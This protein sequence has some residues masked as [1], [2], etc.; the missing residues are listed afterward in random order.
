MYSQSSL[1]LGKFT[2]QGTVRYLSY[3]T[4]S[5]LL[6]T[7]LTYKLPKVHELK[8]QTA[9]ETRKKL[10]YLTLPYLRYVLRSRVSWEVMKHFLGTVRFSYSVVRYVGK[11]G[12]KHKFLR[13]GPIF[14]HIFSVQWSL[15]VRLEENCVTTDF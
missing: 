14:P 1:E 8:P 3:E 2:T 12:R 10:P 6:G 4:S 15:H 13:H 7:Y 5:R 11:V 9:R